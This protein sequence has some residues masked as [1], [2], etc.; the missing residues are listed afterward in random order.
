MST[1]TLSY[2][3]CAKHR[4]S[5]DELLALLEH[6]HAHNSQHNISGLLLYNGASTFLQVL[7]GEQ[8]IVEQLY[9]RISTDKRHH[10]VNCILKKAIEKRDFPDWKMG[11]RN[12]S[13][14]PLLNIEGFS[15]FMQA[16]DATSYLSENASFANTMLKHFKNTSQEILL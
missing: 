7:E 8:D 6:C 4:F 9:L 3:S 12:L 2:I 11:F 5:D 13:K 15:N 14:T 16:S 10:R 1:I